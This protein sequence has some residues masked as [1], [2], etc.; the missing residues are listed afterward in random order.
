ME[1]RTGE[2]RLNGRK[3]KI[4]RTE[5]QKKKKKKEKEGSKERLGK[6][7]DERGKRK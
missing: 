1:G 2:G 7:R 3:I 6:E 5:G 4:G